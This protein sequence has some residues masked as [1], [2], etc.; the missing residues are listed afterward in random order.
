MTIGLIPARALIAGPTK[1]MH[2]ASKQSHTATKKAVE[3]NHPLEPRDR[4]C[5]DEFIN[6][7]TFVCPHSVG[8]SVLVRPERRCAIPCALAP[9]TVRGTNRPL[10]CGP[11][12]ATATP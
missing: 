6:A 8:S 10:R 9:G 7:Q 2:A 11:W 1:P 12:T 3:A 4:V 5:I